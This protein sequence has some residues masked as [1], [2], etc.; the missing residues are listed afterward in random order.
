MSSVSK[1][2]LLTPLDLTLLAS[3]VVLSL[4]GLLYAGFTGIISIPGIK[5][6]LQADIAPSPKVSL[7]AF[8]ADLVSPTASPSA[9]ATP[10]TMVPS[11]LANATNSAGQSSPVPSAPSTPPPKSDKDRDSE[12]KEQVARLAAALDRYIKEQKSCPASAS[13][14]EGRTDSPST[15]LN[16]LVEKGYLSALPVPSRINESETA[17]STPWIGYL[18]TDG[19]NYDITLTLLNKDDPAGLYDNQKPPN[20]LFHQKSLK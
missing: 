16:R 13:Y 7:P 20:Y 14:N 2:K 4:G 6:I 10:I 15:P 17:N 9:D 5:P 19:Q 8:P 12:H 1:H 18:C 11:P 3:I